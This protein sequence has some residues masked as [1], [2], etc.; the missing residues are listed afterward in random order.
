MGGVGRGWERDECAGAARRSACAAAMA[1]SAFERESFEGGYRRLAGLVCDVVA[2]PAVG[3]VLARVLATLRELLRC[4]D[5]VVW[6]TAGEGELAVVLVDGED[7]EQMWGIR[8]RLG[9]GL[10]GLAARHRRVEVSND[11]H[12]DVRAGLVPGTER[13]P[14][15]VT[16]MPLITARSANSG[17]PTSAA[18]TSPA[19]RSTAARWE[20]STRTRS[21]CNRAGPFGESFSVTWGNG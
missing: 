14:E 5:V 17:S 9:E 19:P 16:C 3:S 15:A 6:E 8:I 20:V 18:S 4:E 7:E 13:V 12:A 11:A 1:T 2:E 21:R 10:T